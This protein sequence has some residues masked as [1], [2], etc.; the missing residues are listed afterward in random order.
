MYDLP[1]QIGEVN[2][3]GIRDADRADPG[4]GEVE[5]QRRAKTTCA[6]DEDPGGQKPDLPLLP[7]FIED[8][9]AGVALEL[10][11]TQLHRGRLQS[12]D[13]RGRQRGRSTNS[14]RQNRAT[15]RRSSY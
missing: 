1:L 14:V 5:Q 10:L 11:L 13:P 9:V 12:G 4:G 3:V 2:P 8:Q 15:P 6:N 7:D